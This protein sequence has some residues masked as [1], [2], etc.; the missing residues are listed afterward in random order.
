MS[1]GYSSPESREDH[2]RCVELCE[3]LGLG[4]EL[5]P[6]LWFGWTYY[7]SC[8]LAQAERVCDTLERAAAGMDV[9]ARELGRGVDAFFR[10][11]FAE[12]CELMRAFLDHP[13][14]TTG[15][16][17]AGWPLPND[18]FV[19]VS[20]H[21]TAALWLTGDPEGARAVAERALERLPEL[22]F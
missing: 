1:G 19:S 17:P 9:P 13:W 12:S 3:A 6:S 11:R 20:A 4:P 18:P 2:A 21:L 16:P 15:R 8:D 7:C 14:A 5:L 10:G 22:E